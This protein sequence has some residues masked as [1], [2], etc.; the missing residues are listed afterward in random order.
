MRL[1]IIIILVLL[2][3]GVHSVIYTDCKPPYLTGLS[4]RG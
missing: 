4:D 2:L 3:L 1:V